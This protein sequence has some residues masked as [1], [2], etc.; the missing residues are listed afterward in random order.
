ML[1]DVV[2]N[3]DGSVLCTR[4]I[5][6]PF[7]LTEAVE[8]TIRQWKFTPQPQKFRGELEFHF[9]LLSDAGFAQLPNRVA[10]RSP[11]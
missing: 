9:G 4:I 6:L 8:T 5:G 3:E 2:V 1:A 7:G 10:N 11:F